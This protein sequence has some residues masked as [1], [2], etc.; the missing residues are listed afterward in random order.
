MSTS[1]QEKLKN[2]DFFKQWLLTTTTLYPNLR[3]CYIPDFFS[4]LKNISLWDLKWRND[5]FFLFHGDEEGR[6]I[7]EIKQ[8]SLT[9]PVI[10][11]NII[12]CGKPHSQCIEYTTYSFGMGTVCAVQDST[13]DVVDKGPRNRYIYMIDDPC[14]VDVDKTIGYTNDKYNLEVDFLGRVDIRYIIGVFTMKIHTESVEFTDFTY[15]NP[16]KFPEPPEGKCHII[17]SIQDYANTNLIVYSNGVNIN[18]G[19]RSYLTVDIDKMCTFVVES[20]NTHRILINGKTMSDSGARTY[21]LK[22]ADHLIN[23]VVVF[24]YSTAMSIW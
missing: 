19:K 5:N 21:N 11:N 20:E 10:E 17:L 7:A 14:G 18:E 13:I 16:E 1:E 12:I 15:M 3:K 24:E 6:P 23:G 2:A 22:P 8:Q 9:P 4:K